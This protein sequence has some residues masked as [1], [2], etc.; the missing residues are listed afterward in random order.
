MNKRLEKPEVQWTDLSGLMRATSLRRED[1]I[2]AAEKGYIRSYK[3]GPSKNARVVFC[4]ADAVQMLE[5][6]AVGK[7]PRVKRR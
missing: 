6:L 5:R 1:I 2:E 4:I 3:L 7:E